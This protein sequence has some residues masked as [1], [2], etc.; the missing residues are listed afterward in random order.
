MAMKKTR[1]ATAVTISGIISGK[2]MTPKAVALPLKPAPRD[3]AKAAETAIAV[4]TSAAIP[5]ITSE[6]IVAI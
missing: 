2:L 4:E 3:S 6:L 1:L 5:A